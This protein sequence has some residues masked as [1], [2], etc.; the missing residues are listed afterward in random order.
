M[1]HEEVHALDE[2]CPLHKLRGGEQSR[3]ETAAV[4]RKVPCAVSHLFLR[5][6]VRLTKLLKVPVPFKRSPPSRRHILW[7]LCGGPWY[8]TRERSIARVRILSRCAYGR[9][10]APSSMSLFDSFIAPV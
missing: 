9:T 7:L 5:Y 2:T 6:P 4:R 3:R 10:N 8:V 1:A